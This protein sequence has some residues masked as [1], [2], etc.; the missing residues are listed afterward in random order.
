MMIC[1]IVA[2]K[3]CQSTNAGRFQELQYRTEIS[4]LLNICV[5]ISGTS[6]Y[7]K[8]K[9]QFSHV[10]TFPFCFHIRLFLVHRDNSALNLF[11]I[12]T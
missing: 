2:N 6:V 5:Y 10:T 9:G 4:L 11:F 7:N 3:R 12:K 8:S 1:L